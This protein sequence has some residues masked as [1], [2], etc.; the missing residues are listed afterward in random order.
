M[1]GDRGIVRDIVF[2]LL[3]WLWTLPVPASA[4]LVQGIPKS[5]VAPTTSGERV[6]EDF[7]IMPWIA[8][9]VVY[10]DNVLFSLQ[11]QR[12]DD[13]FVRI[14]P[15]FEA[16]YHSTPL[17]VIAD[18]R[19]DSEV[20]SRLHE[21]DSAQMRQFGTI[22]LRSRP[23]ANWTVSNVLGYAQTNTPFELNVLTGAQVARFRADRYYA[24]PNTEYRF[25]QL[26]R[27]TGQYAYSKDIFVREVEINSHIFNMALERRIGAHD[28]L[29]PAYIGRH[30][31]FGGNLDSPLAGFIGGDARD[32]TSHA[33]V[34]AWSHDFAAGTRLEMRAGPRISDGALDK[35]PELFFG[36]RKRMAG[37][38]W[39]V[40]YSSVVTTII[41]TVGATRADNVT[42]TVTYEPV[43]H[44][45]LTAGPA[46]SWIDN[47]AFSSSIY[48]GYVEA[49][50]QLNKFMTAKGSA[51]FSYQEGN[52]LPIGGA[53]VNNVIIARNVF[54]LRLEFA[55]PSRWQ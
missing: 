39:A 20:Y 45:T 16:S 46:L 43:K 53:T 11:G 6:P 49:A 7:Y 48:T 12:Q 27:M 3:V 30:F 24:N 18:Y 28:T 13:V 10:D 32:F 33:F 34:L 52:F 55:Y 26:T 25:D 15:G 21:L 47:D 8:G 36:L 17:T 22:E 50:Y 2:L 41:G 14:T 35:R 37:G 23:S 31:T 9:G 19:F 38:E 54:W 51:Y 1:R 4:Q 44:L 5:P 42:A 29:G 40:S